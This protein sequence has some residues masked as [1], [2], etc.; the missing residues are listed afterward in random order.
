ML[1]VFRS[2]RLAAS[3]WSS[4]RADVE[5]HCWAMEWQERRWK[6]SWQRWT[7]SKSDW[8]DY[9][10]ANGAGG[11][12]SGRGLAAGPVTVTVRWRFS[13]NRQVFFAVCSGAPSLRLWRAR[14]GENID[15][16]VPEWRTKTTTTTKIYDSD[17]G[18][19]RRNLTRTDGGTD[20]GLR[21]DCDGDVVVAWCFRFGA[22]A[23][24][25]ARRTHTVITGDGC[26][27]HPT[28]KTLYNGKTTVGVARP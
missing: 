14:H 25:S 5:P 4:W 21:I 24:I 12:R 20:D 15:P 16:T 1:F 26:A 19:G 28:P 10:C 17:Y 6:I 18:H 23:V 27:R 7:V 13:A 11:R 22:I 2:Q 8:W 3:T 9:D